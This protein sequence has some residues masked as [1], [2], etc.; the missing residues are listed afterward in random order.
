M[1][2]YG[3]SIYAAPPR[4]QRMLT[5]IQGYNFDILYRPG[6]DMVLADT[7]S[8]LPNRERN[9]EIELDV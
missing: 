6:K 2:T 1:T 9:E 3:K 4:L 5:Q 8:R 7:L